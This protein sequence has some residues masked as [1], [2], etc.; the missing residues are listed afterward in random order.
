LWQKWRRERLEALLAGSYGTDTRALLAICKNPATSPKELI[1]AVT[2]GP[3][4]QA[5]SNTRFE[6][7]SLL[8]G[9]I[10]KRRA[11]A[12]HDPFDDALPGE[13]DT[14]FLILRALI[15][16]PFPSS[17]GAARGAARFVHQ[18]PQSRVQTYD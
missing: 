11:Q 14:P 4:A 12:G 9:F 5:D 2:A 1:V 7:L 13:P 16:Q 18:Q 6:I 3:W 8:D 15:A 10:I 17:D